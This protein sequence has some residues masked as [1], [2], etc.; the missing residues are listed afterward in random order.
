MNKYAKPVV[1]IVRWTVCLSLIWK[2]LNMVFANVTFQTAEQTQMYMVKTLCV[3]GGVLVWM[4]FTLYL[5][6][7]RSCSEDGLSRWLD[8]KIG[9]EWRR[10]S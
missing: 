3:G 4:L 5:F 10:T 8:A 6:P 2:T 1:H 9:R 7:D